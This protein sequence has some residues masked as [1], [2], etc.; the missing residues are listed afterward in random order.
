M[1]ILNPYLS[2]HDNA[3]E[4]MTFY[5]SVLGGKLD[6]VEFSSFPDMPQ[7]PADAGKIMHAWLATDDG[8]VL[9]GS[10]TPTGMEYQPPQGISVSVSCDEEDR[11]QAIWDGL[12][13]GGTVTM[14][15][16]TPPWGGRFGMLI[17][18]FGV[19]WMVTAD[20]D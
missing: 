9:A 18:R 20:A 12:G 19:A 6:L 1:S 5:Q 16:E 3:R 7:D 14:P 4:A 8:M 17:D 11:A 15:F 2:F 10:D 13:A